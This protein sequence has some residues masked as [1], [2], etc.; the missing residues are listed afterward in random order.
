[1]CFSSCAEALQIGFRREVA[2]LARPRGNRV[3]HA[4]D[5]LLDA[6]LALG[7]ADLPAEIFRDDDVGRLLRPEGWD[8]DV[9]L[10]EHH[11]AALVADD[12]RPL[13]PGDLVERVDARQRKKARKLQTR[14]RRRRS[15][16]PPRCRVLRSA[17]TALRGWLL[18][19][20]G[21]VSCASFH[22]HPP[23]S[24]L[25]PPRGRQTTEQLKCAARANVAA[26]EIRLS[27][28]CE[29]LGSVSRCLF[30][31][32]RSNMRPRSVGCQ[33]QN[34]TIYCATVFRSNAIYPHLPSRLRRFGEAGK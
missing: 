16:V 29:T 18:D 31:L 30:A 4:A 6:V 14:R 33:A 22:S 9:A 19:A 34:T 13:L 26:W 10:L 28:F 15:A 20:C 24:W 8:L 3:D 7:R 23:L 21:V 27:S 5:Q 12:G 11:F 32:R 2:V 25:P 1:M 17:V